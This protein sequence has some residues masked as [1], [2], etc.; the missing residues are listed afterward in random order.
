MPDRELPDLPRFPPD[1]PPLDPVAYRLV[2]DGCIDRPLSLTADAVRALPPVTV[3]ADFRCLE[4]W[5][6]RERSWHGVQLAVLLARAGL[7]PGA[8]FI[9]ARAAD[10]DGRYSVLLTREQALAPSAIVAWAR[11]GRPLEH[12]HGAPLR[13]H[14]P[15]AD[16]F[17]Q[18]KWLTQIIALTHE[19][20]AEGPTIALARIGKC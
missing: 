20:P 7:G 10:H 13:L 12:A 16:C 6:V 5:V 15:G 8:R 14:V 2:V 4:G 17:A 3:T 19:V 11:E 1:I 18:V 9:A